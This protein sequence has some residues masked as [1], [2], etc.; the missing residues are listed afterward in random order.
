MLR[1]I[2][3]AL[4]SVSDKAGLIDFARALVGFGCELFSTGRPKKAHGDAGLGVKDG[5]EVPSFPDMLDGRVKTLPPRIHAGIPARRGDPKHVAPLA[6]HRIEP[7]DLVVC[8]LSPLEAALA[9]P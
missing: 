5:S 8:N 2:R 7:I 9:K 1:P 4:L 6:E 3:R